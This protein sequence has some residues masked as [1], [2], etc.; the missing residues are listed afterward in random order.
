MA[1]LIQPVELLVGIKSLSGR[2][3]GL[4]NTENDG[5]ASVVWN[6]SS[7]QWDKAVDIP[8]GAVAG[9]LP[10]PDSEMKELGIPE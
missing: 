9:A 5:I 2:A 10:M 3:V 6:A 7:K 1:R 8:V 4:A